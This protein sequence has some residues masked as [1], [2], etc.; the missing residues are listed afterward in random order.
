M[1]SKKRPIE[2]ISNLDKEPDA[3]T[4]YEPPKA[5]KTLL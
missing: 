3:Y 1:N 5:K 2:N 4:E